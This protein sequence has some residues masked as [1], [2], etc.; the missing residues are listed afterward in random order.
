MIA[1]TISIF[2]QK[3]SVLLSLENSSGVRRHSDDSA[4]VTAMMTWSRVVLSFA[5]KEVELVIRRAGNKSWI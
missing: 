1:S 4:A 5:S 3:I 2:F